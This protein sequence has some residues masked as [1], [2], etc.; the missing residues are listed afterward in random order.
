MTV[1][2][3]LSYN[4]A[5]A[6]LRLYL[7]NSSGSVVDSDTSGNTGSRSVSAS[8]AAGTYYLRV[9]CTSGGSEYDLVANAT[10]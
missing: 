9:Y 4:S 6:N 1:D 7:L 10:P 3:T 2:G 8:V 5:S